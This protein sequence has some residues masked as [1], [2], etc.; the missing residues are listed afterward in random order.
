MSIDAMIEALVAR[1]GGYSNNPADRGGPTNYGITEQVARASG[2][3]GDMRLMPRQVAE[4]I[5]KA[6]YWQQPHF[7]QVA[8][9]SKAIAEELFDTGVNMGVGTA[10]KFLQRLLNGLNRGGK[11]Y[12]DMTVDGDLGGTTLGCLTAFLNQRGKPPGEVVILRGLNCLQGARYI[13]LSEKRQQNETFL[14]GWL[15]NRVSAP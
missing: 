14:Y 10:V 12:P 3:R 5:Y 4:A 6:R 15:L 1:E 11:D 9:R 13:E 7:D 2:Y 8:D